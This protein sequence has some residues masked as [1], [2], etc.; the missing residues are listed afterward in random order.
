MADVLCTRL[1]GNKNVNG[2]LKIL[3]VLFNKI[4]VHNITIYNNS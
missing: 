4:F 2:L 3:T 1:I